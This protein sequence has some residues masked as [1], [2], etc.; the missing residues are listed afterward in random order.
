MDE[1]KCLNNAA[2]AARNN[3]MEMLKFWN[4]Q[5]DFQKKSPAVQKKLKAVTLDMIRNRMNYRNPLTCAA[6]CTEPCFDNKR[7]IYT[8]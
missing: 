5:Y 2:E 4:D 6:L 1:L 8:K 3:D 7:V